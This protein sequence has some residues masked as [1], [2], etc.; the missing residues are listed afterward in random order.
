MKL[1]RYLSVLLFVLIISSCVSDCGL[2][3]IVPTS[4]N[5]AVADA[6]EAEIQDYINTHNLQTQKTSSGLHYIINDSGGTQKPDLC[7]EVIAIYTGYLTNGV[8]FDSSGVSGASFPLSNVILGWQEGIPIFGK[9]GSGKL[10]IPPKL[11]YG[12]G[13]PSALI[14]SNSVLVFDIEILD[15]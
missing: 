3:L 5:T 2:E 13:S 15:F 1:F 14:P 6:N 11:G 10:L 7:D 9:E 8:V 12:P 4:V